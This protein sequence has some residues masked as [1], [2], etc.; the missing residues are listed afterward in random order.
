MT[1]FPDVV[2]SACV[3]RQLIPPGSMV[4]LAV[5]GGADSLALLYALHTL[6]ARLDCRLHAATFDHGARGAASAADAAFVAGVCAALDI[7]V[8]TGRAQRPAASE[9]GLRAARYAFLADA[10][11]AAGAQRIATGHH[12]GDQAETVLLRLARGAGSAG[13]AAMAPLAPLPGQPDLLLIRP[14]LGIPRAD[15]DAYCAQL[16]LAPR[17]DHT[18][19][20]ATYA[21]NRLRLEVIPALE[22]INPQTQRAL[23]RFAA[24]SA[25]END[26]LQQQL[27]Q[28]IAPHLHRETGR[29][30][31]ERAAFQALHPALRW[32]FVHWA[33]HQLNSAAE[34]SFEHVEA[35][36]DL[37]LTAH[38]GAVATLPGGLRLRLDYAHLVV[39]LAAA[40]QPT[41]DFPLLTPGAV[42]TLTIPGVTPLPGGW[43]LH[44]ALTP[45]GTLLHLPGSAR[46]TLRTRRPGDRFAPPGL[47][48]HTQKLKQWLNDQKIPRHLRDQFPLLAA[49]DTVAAVS[50]PT[51]VIS[52][53]FASPGPATQAIWLRW[54][55]PPGKT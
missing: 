51:W 40:P 2:Y 10:A 8:I 23:A 9:A 7:P 32:R 48:G 42:I 22:R 34:V 24:Q 16:G 36:C 30:R 25:A 41:P 18:N 17:H 12:A 43:A 45:T 3:R 4:L 5:S 50:A 26:Y 14:L 6:R 19:D 37:A 53:H 33:A 44:A 13:L 29:I 20:D 52:A 39:E 46:V 11:R 35:A 54:E 49:D 1:A 47:N 21:R 38:T 28:A 31:L 55:A 27:M 15:I